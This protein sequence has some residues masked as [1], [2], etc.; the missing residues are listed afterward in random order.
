MEEY[1]KF[2]PEA[3]L[4]IQVKQSHEGRVRALLDSYQINP[5]IISIV[6]SQN[7]REVGDAVSMAVKLKPGSEATLL[8]KMQQRNKDI[9]VALDHISDPRNLGAIARS[10]AFFGIKDIVVPSRRQVLLTP[11]SVKTAQGGFALTDLT[12]VTN[13][14]RFLDQAKQH[15]YWVVGA[16]MSGEPLGNLAGEYDKTILVLGAEDTGMSDLVMKK[17]DRTVSISSV[18]D[19][20]ESLNV[21]VALGICLYELTKLSGR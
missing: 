16:D 5:K 3:V 10:C 7:D 6:S 2:K 17:C 11:A 18:G 9:I 12:I 15:G 8:E 20:L 4:D 13:L 14:A 1:L 19:S 21:S